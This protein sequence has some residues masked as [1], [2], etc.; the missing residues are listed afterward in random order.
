MSAAGRLQGVAEALPS[1]SDKTRRNFLR[2]LACMLRRVGVVGSS[3]STAGLVAGAA[4]GNT[5]AQLAVP[6]QPPG[7]NATGASGVVLRLPAGASGGMETDG[8]SV[9]PRLGGSAAHGAVVLKT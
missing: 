4:A 5:G 9:P 8:G 6:A 3:S 7:S 1:A 2:R